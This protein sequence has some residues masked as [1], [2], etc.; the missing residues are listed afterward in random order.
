M[1]NLEELYKEMGISK[2]VYDYAISVENGL[3][4]RF[5]KIQETTTY[6]QMK[7]LKAMQDNQVSEACFAATTGYGYNDLGRDKL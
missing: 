4:E 7:V 5:E 6:N 2:E 1:K 3:K